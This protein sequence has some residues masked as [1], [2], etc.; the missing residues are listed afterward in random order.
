MADWIVLP[1]NICTMSLDAKCYWYGN[2]ILVRIS[3]HWYQYPHPICCKCVDGQT[4][5]PP[6]GPPG[7]VILTGVNSLGFGVSSISKCFMKQYTLPWILAYTFVSDTIRAFLFGGRG[8]GWGVGGGGVGGGGWGGG[9]GGG[10]GGWGGWGVGWGVGGVGGGWG[11]GGVGGGGGG[12]G[13]LDVTLPRQE[14]VVNGVSWT[15]LWM[16]GLISVEQ[17]SKYTRTAHVSIGR[18]S[19]RSHPNRSDILIIWL[20]WLSL[21]HFVGRIWDT[22]QSECDKSGYR[23]K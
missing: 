20:W 11:G 21:T 6:I 16:V 8:V 12:G 14:M 3:A 23:Y 17:D 15:S 13:D 7:R 10:G 5:N 9:G 4:K 18:E 22:D 1:C 19:N 2:E